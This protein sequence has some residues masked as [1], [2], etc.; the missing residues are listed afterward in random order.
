MATVIA[1]D[2]SGWDVGVGPLHARA[3]SGWLDPPA[4]GADGIGED[5]TPIADVV[6]REGE[7]ARASAGEDVAR[8]LDRATQA[9]TITGKAEKRMILVLDTDGRTLMHGRVQHKDG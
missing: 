5:G 8:Q 1:A 4:T 3:S 2:G 6:S 7:R 9:R